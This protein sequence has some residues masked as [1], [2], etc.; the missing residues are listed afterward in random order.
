MSSVKAPFTD[1]QIQSI[2]AYQMSGAFHPFT[3]GTPGC[4]AVLMA[5]R[6][7]MICNTCHQWHQDWVHT[8]MANWKWR[9]F[10]QLQQAATMDPGMQVAVLHVADLE[11]ILDEVASRLAAKVKAE[12]AEKKPNSQYWRSVRILQ[13]LNEAL[14]NRTLEEM[15][16]PAYAGSNVDEEACGE[17][18]EEG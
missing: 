8:E 2:N 3:C 14:L 12:E 10:Q 4:R 5:T 17:P 9:E 7:G 11:P 18:D 16:A 1:D 15:D 6:D 13:I